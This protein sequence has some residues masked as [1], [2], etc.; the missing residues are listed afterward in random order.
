MYVYNRYVSQRNMILNKILFFIIKKKNRKVN[1]D[2]SIFSN[3]FYKFFHWLWNRMICSI[4]ERTTNNSYCQ[5]DHIPFFEND[6]TL[7]SMI[8]ADLN[9]EI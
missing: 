5:A 3:R 1:N 7:D 9:S 2:H 6:K 8:Y 4:T